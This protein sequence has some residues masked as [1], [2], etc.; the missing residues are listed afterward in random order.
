M[1]FQTLPTRFGNTMTDYIGT[2]S[3]PASHH[4]SMQP[5]Q[6]TYKWGAKVLGLPQAIGVAQLLRVQYLEEDVILYKVVYSCLI[7]HRI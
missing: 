3:F 6:Q 2:A 7:P 1:I 5:W 4:P